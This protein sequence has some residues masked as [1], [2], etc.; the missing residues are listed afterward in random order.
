MMKFLQSWLLG[1]RDGVVMLR[2]DTKR[3]HVY[4]A[5]RV[6]EIRNRSNVS[7]W[8]YVPKLNPADDASRGIN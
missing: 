1:G 4:V 8:N 6:Q 7:D 3:F 5:N 2:N